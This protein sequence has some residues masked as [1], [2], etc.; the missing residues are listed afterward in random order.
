MKA[1]IFWIVAGLLLIAAV[2][3]FVLVRPSLAAMRAARGLAEAATETAEVRTIQA[4]TT[5][6][7]S[8]AVE[9]QQQASLTWQTTGTIATV[10]V[11]V[12]DSVQAGD[13]LMTL[14]P[15]SAATNVIQARS[16]LISAQNALDD[17]LHPSALSIANAEQ[18]VADAE[19]Q[20][21]AAQKDLRGIANP[22]VDYYADQVADKEQALLT[23]QQNAEKTNIGDLSNALENARDNLEDKT[24]QLNDART[25]QELCPGCTTLFINATGR[26]MELSQAQ[27]EYDAALNSLRVAELNYQQALANNDDAV[28]AAQEALDDARANLAGAQAGPDAQDV[29][30]KQVAVAQAEAALADA[31]DQLDTLVNGADPDDIAAA[32]VRVEAAQAT[33]DSIVLR[34]PFAG[35][36]LAVNYQPGDPVAQ[37]IVPVVLANR[38]RLHVDVAVDETEVGQI[39]LGDPVTLTVDALPDLALGGTVG[40]VE[41]FGQTVAGLVRYNVR[42][43]LTETDPR[44]YL[45]MTASAV[46]VTEVL[47]NALAV[48]LEAVQY[49]DDGEYVNRI[50]LAGAVERV[51]VASGVIDG[52]WVTVTGDLEP[53]DT[54]QLAPP[55][56]PSV[57]PFGPG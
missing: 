26:R 52:D 53:G 24:N 28:A 15:A 18:A 13:P 4:M 21:E 55:E 51:N 38:S 48:P 39:A 14:D 31:Q 29:A 45:N 30:Q 19:E 6:E 9:P 54:V 8:G 49:D 41:T 7:A 33:L 23:A 50:G 16:D 42:V 5:V 40:A 10:D 46:I 1:R 57:G 17:L 11:A 25:A 32:E 12:G 47:D 44:L 27:E 3:A 22:D 34:A 43:D 20:L 2:V 37:D 35:E 36:V 56:A